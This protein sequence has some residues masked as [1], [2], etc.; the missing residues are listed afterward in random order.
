MPKIATKHMNYK[1]RD[2]LK[3]ASFKQSDILA[4]K[5]KEAKLL[6]PKLIEDYNLPKD[7]TFDKLKMSKGEKSQTEY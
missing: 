5:L 1:F 4:K 2:G 3:I 6:P 7:I